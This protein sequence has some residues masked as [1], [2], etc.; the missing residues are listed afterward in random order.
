[1]T[2][3]ADAGDLRHEFAQPLFG[4]AGDSLHCD[5]FSR[6]RKN[7]SENLAEPALSKKLFLPKTPGGI[8]EILVGKTMGAGDELP[9][10]DDISS[11]YF[12]DNVAGGGK[13]C[14]EE[15]QSGNR[16]GDEQGVVFFLGLG[17]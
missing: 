13:A 11:F 2:K 5:L 4:F 15:K 10:L 9:V 6:P 8:L 1:M 3:P 14:N 17:E 16:D 7:S 12:V